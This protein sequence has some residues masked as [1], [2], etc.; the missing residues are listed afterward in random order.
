MQLAAALMACS[1]DPLGFEF[2]TLDARVS[3]VARREGFRVRP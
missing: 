2:V 1:E 3:D